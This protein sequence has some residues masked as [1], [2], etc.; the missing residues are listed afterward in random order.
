M[1]NYDYKCQKCEHIFEVFQSMNDAKLT[2]CP[3]EGCDGEVKRLLG[4]GAGLIFKGAGFYQTDYRSDSYKAGEKKAASDSK[5][6]S[7]PDKKESKPKK[8]S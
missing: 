1:P 6:A 7:K 5:P 3:Q 2:D 4:T 8:D